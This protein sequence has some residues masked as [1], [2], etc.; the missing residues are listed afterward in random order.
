[1]TAPHVD[2]VARRL[3]AELG[4]GWKG[5]VLKDGQ[6]RA[7]S[8]C[9]RWKVHPVYQRDRTTHKLEIVAYNAF[10]GVR[11]SDGGRYAGSG[12]SPLEA[13][14]VTYERARS[15]IAD[16]ACLLDPA[17]CAGIRRSV[18]YATSPSGL[19]Y[20]PVMP[21]RQRAQRK[22]SKTPRKATR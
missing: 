4:N 20:K 13:V 15:D 11:D 7:V 17:P 9:K 12:R 21:P 14:A 18:T 10:L 5:E 1:M 3:A 19:V 6:V 22:R 8:P 16:I 2:T